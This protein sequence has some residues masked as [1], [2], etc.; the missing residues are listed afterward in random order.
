MSYPICIY[1]LSYAACISLVYWSLGQLSCE[2]DKRAD[3]MQHKLHRPLQYNS[4]SHLVPLSNCGYF[5][6][7]SYTRLFPPTPLALSYGKRYC[8]FLL[9]WT[10][11]IHGT[12]L[13]FQASQFFR[14]S[15]CCICFL[16]F[17]AAKPQGRLLIL[18]LSLSGQ[19]AGCINGLRGF[20]FPQAWMSMAFLRQRS[21]FDLGHN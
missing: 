19:G 4:K 11:N 13:Y 15:F 10:Q 17:G 16:A 8:F 1:L 9:L 18:H 2:Q 20:L 12:M 7:S 6:S 21:L 3:L 5:A 14:V